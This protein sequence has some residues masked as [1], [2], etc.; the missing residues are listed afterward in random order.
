MSQEDDQRLQHMLQ[1]VQARKQ[2]D[3]QKAEFERQHL[4]A[5]AKH[6][7][8]AKPKIGRFVGSLKSVAAT[9]SDEIKSTGVK[10]HVETKELARG[11]THAVVTIYPPGGS[12]QTATIDLT[13]TDKGYVSG[14]EYVTGQKGRNSEVDEITP[15][16]LRGAYIRLAE[17]VL[18]LRPF[19]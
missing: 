19:K 14:A 15:D 3:V 13:I 9:V 1:Q 17:R 10:I 6:R 5:E 4:E 8:E 18:G 7:E 16:M 12:G 11:A 2:A